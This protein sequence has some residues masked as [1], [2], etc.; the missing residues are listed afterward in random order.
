MSEESKQDIRVKRLRFRSWHRGMREVDL[1]MGGFADIHLAQFSPDQLS[2]YERILDIEDPH[3]YA[4][5]SGGAPL[6]DEENS[7]VM[8][9]IM[10]FRYTV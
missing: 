2:Q 10:N 5:I 3:L 7:P 1:I 4:W 8:Q 9:M 6:P